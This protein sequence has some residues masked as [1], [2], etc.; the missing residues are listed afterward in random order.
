VSTP[1]VGDGVGEDSVLASD[2][3]VNL[4]Q[5]RPATLTVGSAVVVFCVGS[6]HHRREPVED[7]EIV[8]DGCCHRAAAFGM[9]RPDLLR[10][11]H[12]GSALGSQQ[13]RAGGGCRPGREDWRGYLSGFW[14]TI[15]VAARDQPGS[16]E[17]Q[18]AVRL[19]GGARIVAHL[20]W[21]DL[22]E[23]EPPPV[24]GT[25]NPVADRLIAICMATFEPD[26]KL[27]R[28]QLDSLRAQS[29]DRW[30]CMISDDRSSPARFQ[31]IVREVGDDRRF[32]L[33]RSDSRL[34][35]YRN[36]ERAL[37]MVPAEAELV[38]L[39]DQD[40]R[41][42]PEKLEVLR[43]ALGDAQLVYSD[44]R[45]V[46][47]EGRVLR[48]TLFEGRRNNSNNLAS[49]LVANT[50]AGAA[51]LFRREV[52][53]LALPFPDAP[54]LQVHDHWLGLVAMA[55]GKV[56]F[57]DRVL[58]DYVQHRGAVFGH[59]SRSNGSSATASNRSRRP[60]LR[61][62][63]A[64]PGRWRAAYFYGYLPREMQALTL[65]TR[66]SSSLTRRKRR[67]LRRFLASSRSPAAFA[68]LA[69]RPLRG[70]LG[71]NET[72]GSEADLARGI[73]WRW[74]T[75]SR[76]KT[77][78]RLGRMTLDGTIPDPASFDQERLRRWRSRL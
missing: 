50:I 8:I 31:E 29:D 40:D 75:A 73:L 30:V 47:A 54:G 20:G 13:P 76:A 44:L 64:R 22:V 43:S 27:F 78:Q 2:L 17:L 58:Y 71:L 36:F 23:P 51:M 25:R 7:L 55:T 24:R 18:V 12:P 9:P 15:P 1:L 4:E 60:S 39:C 14:A 61:R 37:R 21:I 38:A 19:A 70:V 59:V 77:S 33:S 26:M 49:Q 35:F 56:A 65:L 41:W 66:C 6:C 10:S 28:A 57:V 46:D 32:V 67:V 11:R 52:A 62:S 45:L 69:S 72:L 42:Y 74:L 34:G 3:V 48:D 68:W 16:I 53:Q 5:A 63:R